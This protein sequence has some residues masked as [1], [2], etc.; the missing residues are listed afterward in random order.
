MGHT[1][2]WQLGKVLR[3]IRPSGFGMST[4]QRFMDKIEK[5]SS[6]WLWTAYK[7]PKGYGRFGTNYAHRFSYEHFVG[8]IPPG[9]QM[10][11]LCSNT[12]C[13][14]PAH[15]E[16]VTLLENVKR[17]MDAGRSVIGENTRK[18]H[19]PYGHEYTRTDKR[20][21]RVCQQCKNNYSKK[22]RHAS[23]GVDADV[24]F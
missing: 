4:I 18:T 22:K 8:P 5:T 10:D 9:M 1:L 7:N 24:P 16:A 19:C 14:N 23:K 2:L 12:S 11:H 3:E 17:Q 13:V 6:C 21:K 15:L 20:G